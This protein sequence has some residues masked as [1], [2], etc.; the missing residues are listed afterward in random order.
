MPRT[1][2]FNS[3]ASIRAAY[4]LS[5]PNMSAMGKVLRSTL[6]GAVGLSAIKLPATFDHG[7]SLGVGKCK[8]AADWDGL[9]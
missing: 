5:W 8:A 7:H 9:R 2:P 4:D 6:P 1:V 3:N